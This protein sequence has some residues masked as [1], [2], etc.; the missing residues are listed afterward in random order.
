MNRRITAVCTLEQ[1][2][3]LIN[4]FKLLNPLS[5]EVEKGNTQ[6]VLKEFD[7]GFAIFGYFDSTEGDCI[8]S[9]EEMV[10]IFE[11]AY[12]VGLDIA[13]NAHFPPTQSDPIL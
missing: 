8:I 13:L 5:I 9:Y 6:F 11:M 10:I 1:F 4:K 7:N 2:D 3:D 12:V